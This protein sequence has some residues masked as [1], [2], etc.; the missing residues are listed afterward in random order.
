MSVGKS[1]H[2]V[3]D[4][5]GEPS[6]KDVKGLDT[7]PDS[8][9]DARK[10]ASPYGWRTTLLTDGEGKESKSDVCFP[11]AGELAKDGLLL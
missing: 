1:Y 11:C 3:C 9:R 2:L 6:T 5:C 4:R 7:P 10:A 8:A